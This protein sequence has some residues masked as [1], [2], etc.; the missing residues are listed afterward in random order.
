MNWLSVWVNT[1]LKKPKL[2][3]TFTGGVKSVLYSSVVI[4][5]L[6][7][8]SSLMGQGSDQLS[9]FAMNVIVFPIALFVILVIFIALF[10]WMAA[11]HNGK[12]SF[13]KDFAVFGAYAGSLI[14]VMGIAMF[15]FGL[16]MATAL[17]SASAA[18]INYALMF[19]VIGIFAAVLAYLGAVVFSVWFEE[20]A[21]TEKLSTFTAAK[22][23]GVAAA[24]MVFVLAIIFGSYIELSLGPYKSAL[25]GTNLTYGA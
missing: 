21:A 12:G 20:L 24:V 2:K 18:D 16:V 5:V 1:F 25:A 6:N 13:T 7:F 9:S 3:Y 10:R 11:M 22:A 17:S 4:G 19:L 14:F 23:F 15:L 8:L